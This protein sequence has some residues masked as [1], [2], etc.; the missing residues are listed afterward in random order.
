MGVAACLSGMKGCQITLHIEN[1]GKTTTEKLE[2][3]ESFLVG[4]VWT[5]S[6]AV[7]SCF[8]NVMLSEGKHSNIV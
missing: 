8:E 2:C 4:K 6:G 1:A 3:R 7:E 5:F